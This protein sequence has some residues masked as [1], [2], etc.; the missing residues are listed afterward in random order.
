[1]KKVLRWGVI[2]LFVLLCTAPVAVVFLRSFRGAEGGLS[3]V[4]YLQ[5]LFRT[6]DFYRAYWNSVAYTVLIILF[7]IPISVLTAYGFFR[8]RFPGKNGAFRLYIIL[9]LMPFQATIVP[10]YLT[11][12]ALGLIEQ[13]MAV[14][15]PNIFA[16]FGTILM[17]QQMKGLDRS[18]FDAAEMDGFSEFQMMT[19][20]AL[21]TV[22]PLVFALTTL[23]FI[24]YWS[25][26]EQPLIFLSE[27]S[28]LP[29]SMILNSSSRFRQ[30]A[31]SLGVL[32]SVLPLLIY[33][34]TYDDLVYGIGLS[35]NVSVRQSGKE[36]K[37]YRARRRI[38]GFLV[39]MAVANFFS[40][41]ILYSERAKV[42]VSHPV[43]GALGEN[44]YDKEDVSLGYFASVLPTSAV[45]E[46]RGEYCVYLVVA[47][48]SKL[49][50][51]QIVKYKVSKLAENKEE[52]AVYGLNREDWVVIRSDRMLRESDFVRVYYD[53]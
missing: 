28:H 34:A 12:K 15:L 45:H 50:R 40:E 6:E 9:M 5:A 33:Q 2:Y 3:A 36:K 52:V 48:K 16:T 32:F 37:K 42:E 13:P 49:R 53:E 51:A 24:N 10:Q 4:S 18:L 44:P 23:S 11:L 38:L 46:D 20:I 26:V 35:S 22:K 8:F 47:E 7:N 43:S 27:P 21:P 29:L 17:I 39:F 14:I 1:M 41:K 19:R 31:Y 30:V 25:M